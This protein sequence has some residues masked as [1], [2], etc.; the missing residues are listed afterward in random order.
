MIGEEEQLLAAEMRRCGISGKEVTKY[1][2]LRAGFLS[3]QFI[4]VYC[5]FFEEKGQMR[6]DRN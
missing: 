6:G 2:D 1:K 4:L 5:P 3:Y